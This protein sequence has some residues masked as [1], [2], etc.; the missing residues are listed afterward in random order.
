MGLK[1][2]YAKSSSKKTEYVNELI[3]NFLNENEKVILLVPEQ[4]THIAEKNVLSFCDAISSDKVDVL[5]FNH[6]AYRVMN[7][8]GGNTKLQI[9]NMGKSLII[10]DIISNLNLKL[11]SKMSAQGGFVNS[12]IDIISE[13]KQYNVL[14]EALLNASNNATNDLFSAKMS[15]LYEIYSAYLKR[16]DELYSDAEDVLETLCTS[17]ECNDIFNDY[18]IILDEFSSFIPKEYDIIYNLIKKC[19]SVHITLNIDE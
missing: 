15:D 2:V 14:P 9:N 16:T 19:K 11:Y 12:C 8:V 3:N 17:L 18:H 10:S 1:L 13:L 4:Y 6:M 7:E 5:S